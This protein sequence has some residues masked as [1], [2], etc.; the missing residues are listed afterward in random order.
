MY[1]ERNYEKH[2]QENLDNGIYKPISSTSIN[3]II[4]DQGK[5]EWLTSRPYL[6]LDP[7][8]KKTVFPP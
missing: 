5:G 8:Y 6:N 3:E 7:N 1:T 2:N 4:N